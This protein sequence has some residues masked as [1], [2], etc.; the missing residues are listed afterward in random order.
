MASFSSDPRAILPPELPWDGKSK[1]LLVSPTDEW[2]TPFEK[3]G[4]NQ[5]PGYEET[6]AWLQKLLEAAPELKRM[7][8]GSSLEGREIFMIL[9]SADQR[10]SP[11]GFLAS[12]KPTVFI[13][14]CIH[15]GEPDGKDAGLMLLR[16]LTVKGSKRA[17]LE[18]VNILFVPIYNPDGHERSSI[19]GRI[20]QRG[21]VETG[22]RTNA[23]NLNLNR[24]YT[25]LDAPETR[26][27]VAA[28]TLWQP[29]LTIDLHVTDGA[30]YQYDITWAFASEA[31]YSPRTARWFQNNLEPVL[32]SDLRIMGHLTSRYI[33]LIDDLDPAKGVGG[34]PNLPRF[35][36]GYSDIRHLPGLLVETH[37]LKSYLQR[38][39]GTYVLLESALTFVAQDLAA[40]R[41]AIAEDKAEKS[42]EFITQWATSD[43]PP[44][45]MEF[46]GVEYR[47]SHSSISGG[48]KI[49]W[50]GT[51]M[52][53]KIPAEP[54]II[55]KAKVLKPLAYWVPPQWTQVMERL[56]AHGISMEA[57][58]ESKELAVEMYRI[59]NPKIAGKPFE[60]RVP[61][62]GT[63]VAERRLER[64]PARS[65]RVPVKPPF[66]DLI[67]ALLEPAS[68]DSFFS[69]GFFLEI[70]QTTEYVEG[71]IMEP[72]AEKML[73]DDPALALEFE[74]KLQEDEEF[75]DSPTDR[76]LWFYRRTP[77]YDDR[78]GLYPVAREIG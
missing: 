28:L 61:V 13:Q 27:I 7:S 17:L 21:P 60:G 76:L 35:S 69:W 32:T 62:T 30:D 26:A 52:T 78:A 14:A 40:L 37:S 68:A 51:P 23:R 73:A 64:F 72:M 12:G 47:R 34:G 56:A 3:S 53:M 54:L 5:S 19:Y 16:D 18:K 63:P 24:D 77:F 11:E 2:A 45:S 31:Q 25:K 67:C 20:N 75:R 48:P 65:V 4:L 42:S 57:L 50:L 66:G 39:L 15:P 1:S 70:I 46:F 22:W 36:T 58:P 55:P 41:H 74:R 10:F 33:N 59:Q 8:L 43:Q 9:A 71:Y 49:E 44:P 38:V 29:D 6:F